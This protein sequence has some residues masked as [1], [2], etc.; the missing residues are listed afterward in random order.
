[1]Q[2]FWSYDPRV[3]DGRD[4]REV[5]GEQFHGLEGEGGP[6]RGDVRVAQVAGAV[7]GQ[8]QDHHVHDADLR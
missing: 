7:H 1:M 6:G 4:P 2:T 3:S 5:V 8:A